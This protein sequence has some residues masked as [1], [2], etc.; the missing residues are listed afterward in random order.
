VWLL[1]VC[2]VY[3]VCARRRVNR[4]G[5]KAPGAVRL[6]AVERFEQRVP[7]A[8]IAAELR[9]SERSVRRWRHAWLEGGAAGLA[10]RGQAARCRLDEAQ[11]AVLDGLL[12]AG[13]LAAGWQDPALDAGP[14]PGSGRGE[15]RGGVHGGGY[16]VPAAPPRLVVPAGRAPGHRA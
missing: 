10:S 6:G 8:V 14:D 15:V 3:A 12:E 4:R 13:P 5:P 16:L 1:A 11:L 2:R 7:A 9:V